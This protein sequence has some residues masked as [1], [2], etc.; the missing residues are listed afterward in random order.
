MAYDQELA[1]RIRER[2]QSVPRVKEKEMMG[3]LAFMVN[4]KMCVGIFKDDMM[5]RIDPDVRES[6]LARQGCHVMQ[7]TGRPMKGFV[8]VD[9]TGMRSAKD[10]NYW[11]D[12][13]LAFNPRARASKKRVAKKS[14]GKKPAKK[15]AGKP[16]K[17]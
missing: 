11:I 2:L 5:C 10:F 1:A 8:L 15:N 9:E 3:G 14:T 17:R 13:C 7:F 4:N 12:L 16:K 6:A